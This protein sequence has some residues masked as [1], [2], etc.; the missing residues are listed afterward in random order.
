MF[1]HTAARRRLA[2]SAVNVNDKVEFQHTAARRRL[3]QYRRVQRVCF[4]VST[5]SRPK[6]AGTM[7]GY[8]ACEGDVS[9]HSRPKAAGRYLENQRQKRNGFNTQPPE[10]GWAYGEIIPERTVSFQ[11]TAA[12]RRLVRTI[13]KKINEKEFQHTA[14]RRR[15]GWKKIMAGQEIRFQHTA[16]RRRLGF[17]QGVGLRAVQVS[18]HSR[19]K[20][21]GASLKSLAPSGFAAPISLSS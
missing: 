19:P 14:A 16:A 6:A 4:R 18:T 1:Q 3:G 13:A 7:D 5:H 10:G 21:A 9:T 20:A 17:E 15:L 2:L 11:H 8:A 12:R